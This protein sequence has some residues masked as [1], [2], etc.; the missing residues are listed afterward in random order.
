MKFILFIICAAT[1]LATSGCV[2]RGDHRDGDHR[3]YSEHGEHGDH[4]DHG[5]HGGDH[6]DDHH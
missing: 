1:L 2:Y 4:G 6:G 5:D 3:G